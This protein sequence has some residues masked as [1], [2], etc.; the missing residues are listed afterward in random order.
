[1]DEAWIK[2]LNQMQKVGFTN[3]LMKMLA[4]CLNSQKKKQYKTTVQS[5]KT[6]K[7]HDKNQ[8]QECQ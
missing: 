2:E 7:K 4:F 6:G 8:F 5:R 3:S 1:M